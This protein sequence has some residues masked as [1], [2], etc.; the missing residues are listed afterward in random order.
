[1]LASRRH[2][3]NLLDLIKINFGW[4]DFQKKKSANLRIKDKSKYANNSKKSSG[5]TGQN[6]V[7]THL[8]AMLYI[9]CFKD[10]LPSHSLIAALIESSW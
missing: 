6:W 1:M 9:M 10:E 4:H 8:C 5:F 7:K 2:V 3:C